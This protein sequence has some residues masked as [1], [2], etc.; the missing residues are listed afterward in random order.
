MYSQLQ[1]N[2]A[3]YEW[4]ESCSCDLVPMVNTFY[5]KVSGI[6][7]YVHHFLAKIYWIAFKIAFI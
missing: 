4:L 7:E 2:Y 3:F 1:Q 5:Q 6:A